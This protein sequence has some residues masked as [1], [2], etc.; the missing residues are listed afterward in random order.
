MRTCGPVGH[1]ITANN[2][3]NISFWCEIEMMTRLMHQTK[4]GS[5]RRL[6]GGRK[7][8]L[9][10]MTVYKLP[11]SVSSPYLLDSNQSVEIL[12]VVER[13]DGFQLD[14]G[15]YLTPRDMCITL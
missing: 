2:P 7:T 11:D 14:L 15:S 3:K 13:S 10:L 6:S 9:S 12:T 4:V 1:A 8:L 5:S